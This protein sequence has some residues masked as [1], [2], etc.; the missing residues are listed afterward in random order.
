MDTFYQSRRRCACGRQWALTE[1]DR[2][3]DCLDEAERTHYV[4]RVHRHYQEAQD[5]SGWVLAGV[6]FSKGSWGLAN[7]SEADVRR[8]NFS[9]A[10]LREAILIGTLAEGANFHDADLGGANLEFAMLAEAD[11]SDAS[12]ERANLQR[13]NLVGVKAQN[14]VFRGA[15]MYYS[16]TGAGDFRDA[17]FSGANIQRS[18]FRAAELQ[19]AN[20][21][22]TTGEANFDKAKR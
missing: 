13:A 10:N 22:N 4:E 19:G 2:C 20:F 8:A 7:F 17:D 16:R 5:F 6:N 15:M 18:I 9:S 21:K 11:I 3:W 1:C 12:F 14:T